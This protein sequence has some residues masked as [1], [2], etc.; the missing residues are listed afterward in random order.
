[1]TNQKLVTYCL[2]FHQISRNKN[3]ILYCGQI[4][5][6]HINTKQVISLKYVKHSISN[7]S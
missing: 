1:M 4:I 5:Y 6:L 7:I 3:S 2:N